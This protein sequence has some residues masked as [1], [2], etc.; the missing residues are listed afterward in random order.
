MKKNYRPD[1]LCKTVGYANSDGY[2]SIPKK[3]VYK[4]AYEHCGK[5]VPNIASKYS[6]AVYIISYFATLATLDN[7]ELE[8]K[9][10][11]VLN[12]SNLRIRHLCGCKLC[13]VTNHLEIGT[14]EKNHED[15]HYH[16]FLQNIIPSLGNDDDIIS[17]YNS[18]KEKY[19]A[20]NVF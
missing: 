12:D 9:I 20:E 1:K 8:K 14:S 18:F 2:A 4:S 5:K 6:Y 15:E 19:I 7:D 10:S 11:T 16:F 3:K 17:E 13:I